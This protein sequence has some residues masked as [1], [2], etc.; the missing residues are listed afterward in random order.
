[1][2]GQCRNNRV[3]CKAPTG[4]DR[5]AACAGKIVAI[6]A[7]DAFDDTETAQPCELPGEGSGRAM[8]EQWQEVGA[9]EAGDVEAGTLQGRKQGLFGAAK[10]V[11]PADVAAFDGAGLGKT[12]EG[13]ETGREVV[14]SGE[15]S[16]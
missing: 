13:S 6:G 9:A 7:G 2:S 8:A 1:M 10:E 15:Y 11:E 12:V 4:S 16:R 14:Q 3:F 5:G